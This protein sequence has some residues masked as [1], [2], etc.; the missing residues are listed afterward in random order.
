MRILFLT[1]AHNSLSQRAAIELHQRGHQVSVELAISDTLMLEAVEGFNPDL[2]LAPFLKKAIPEAIWAHYKCFVVH[3]GI[4][5]DRGPSSLDWAIHGNERTWGVTI[6]EANAE[7]DAG[8]IWATRT[9][10]V[11]ARPVSKSSLYRA[12]VTE[13]AIAALLE[14]VDKLALGAAPEP[15]DVTREDVRGRLRPTMK[16]DDRRIDW[17]RDT[18]AT[19]VRKIRAADSNPGL[20]DSLF[21]VDYFLFGAHE[22]DRLVGT[23]GAILAQRD[24]AICRATPDG[25]VWISHL[26]ERR[27]GEPTMKLPAVMALAEHSV[28]I[29][30]VAAPVDTDLR[31]RSLREIRYEE[32]NGVGYLHFDFYNGAM[33]TDQCARLR[34]AYVL[35]RSRPTGVV[36]LLGGRDFWSNGIHLNTIEAA[37]NPADESWANINAINDLIL[38]ILSTETQLV[39]AGIRGNAGAGGAMLALAADRIYAR[40]N[41]VLNAHYKSLG[42]YGSEYWTYTLPRRIGAERA[43]LLTEA[44]LPIGASEAHAIGLVDGV[45][46]GD[47]AAFDVGFKS[48]VE[49]LAANPELSLMLAD[50]VKRRRLDEETKPLAAYRQEE[51]AKMRDNFYGHDSNYHAARRRFVYKVA[52]T[53]TCARVAVHRAPVKAARTIVFDRHVDSAQANILPPLAE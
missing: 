31:G 40:S 6:L 17:A 33:S 48:M 47:H 50:K 42:L 21:G 14:A 27:P 19:V 30:V 22:E 11:Q 46:E 29:P 26:K 2:V 39:V 23:P 10:A 18:T 38:E 13:A 20:L 37:T 32:G 4:K 9:F 24:G 5:G 36:A 25:A 1:T 12:A 52:P 53:Q 8:D 3:P 15:L 16:Q 41:V 35:A 43:G 51:L 34:D 7:M 28:N 49:R 45:I 44:C